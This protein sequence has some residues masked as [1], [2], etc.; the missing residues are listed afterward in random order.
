[1]PVECAA[2]SKVIGQEEFHA[3]DRKVMGEVFAIHNSMGRFL[4]ERIY[5]DELAHRC[6]NAG[7]EVIREVEV[8]VKHRDFQKSYFI[9]LLLGGGCLYELKTTAAL[10]PKHDRQVIHYLL[11]SGLHHGK[12]VNIR[13]PSVESRFIS[14]RLNLTDRQKW[15]LDDRSWQ[16][17]GET[18]VAFRELLFGLLDDLGLFLDAALY[19][20]ALLH[21]T[22]AS[23]GGV[24]PVPVVTGDRVA[25]S[26]NLC[27]L[28][29]ECAW[30]LSTNRENLDSYEIHL[31]RLLRNT[32]LQAMH[33][34][35]L[36]QR[37]VTL[38]NLTH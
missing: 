21:L 6:V 13:P 5:Q 15:S 16:S 2:V 31:A 22:K 34:V 29:P 7:L 30:H 11:L 20:E 27:L 25:G 17:C 37:Q 8:K 38:K 14:T 3:I 26:Q 12:L 1:M 18:G 24:R 23:G 4:D 9:D 36:N 19:K 10:L 32:P 33:W 35:N 28:N